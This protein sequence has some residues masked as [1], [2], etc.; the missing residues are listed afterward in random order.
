MKTT[1]L[2]KSPYVLNYKELSKLRRKQTI[3]LESEQKHE[4][5]KNMKQVYEKFFNIISH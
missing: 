3:Q 4:H 2:T 5:N 1:Y